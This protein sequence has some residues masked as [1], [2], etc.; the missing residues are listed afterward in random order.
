ML[1]N[2]K[3][4]LFDLDGTLVDSMWI[5]KDI[6]VEF[7]KNYDLELPENLQ[8]E[9][10]GKSFTETAVYFK[11]RFHLKESI[12]KIKE[13]WNKMAYERYL[14][15]VPMK[16]GALSFLK[17]LKEKGFKLGIATSN[18]KELVK[19][20]IKVHGLDRFFDSIRTSCDVGLGKPSPDIYL[21][22]ADDLGI[23]P[24]RCIVFEDVPNGILAG[25]NARMKVCTIF[26]KFSMDQEIEKRALADYYIHSYEDI[27]LGTYEVLWNE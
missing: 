22:V 1:D 19:A 13:E 6:D 23:E 10:E 18:S 21:K 8:K 11:N 15:Q 27:R 25:K 7:L 16:K 9:I 2:M 26:D 4:A 17:E 24:S 12:E 20:I 5:W 3:A 14:T